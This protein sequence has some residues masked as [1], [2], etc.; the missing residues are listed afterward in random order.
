MHW[1]SLQ[2]EFLDFAL[3]Q[4]ASQNQHLWMPVLESGKKV[5]DGN[6]DRIPLFALEGCQ[7]P[8]GYEAIGSFCREAINWQGDEEK[9]EVL[10]LIAAKEA[11]ARESGHCVEEKQLY[12]QTQSLTCRHSLGH[13]PPRKPFPNN[14]QALTQL[15]QHSDEKVRTLAAQSDRALETWNQLQPPH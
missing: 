8:S 12:N 1:T 6:F 4:V 3:W 15:L 7:Y 11:A 2:D 5:F 13:L 14:T 9:T 10:R